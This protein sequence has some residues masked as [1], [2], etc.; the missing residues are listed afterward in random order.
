MQT[1]KKT[2]VLV[3]FF[4]E[5]LCVLATGEDRQFKVINASNELADNSAQCVVCTKTGRIIISTVGNLNFYDG[6]NFTHIDT[7]QDYQYQL[8]LYSGNYHLY[9]DR[10]HHL[11]LKNTH[12]VTCVDLLMEKFIANPDSVVR[13]MG[14][15]EPV[16][17]FFTD[18]I[19]D[20][21]VVTEKGLCDIANNR[22]FQILR[23][24]NLQDISVHGNLLLTFYDN[25]EE[26]GIDLNT[27]GIAHRSK[28][29]EWEDARRYASSTVCLNDGDV[30]YQIRNGNQCSVL[31]RFDL[32]TLQWRKIMELPY[33]LNDL[34]LRNG[35]LYIASAYGYWQYDTQ[36]EEKTHVE[37]LALLNGTK[38]L[39][40]CNTLVFDKQGGM[41]I[42]TEQRGLLYARPTPPAFKSYTWEHPLAGKYAAMFEGVTQ[43]ITEFNGKKANCMYVDSRN[44]SWFGTTTGLYLYRSPK[45]EPIVFSRQNG[46][47]NNV[48]HS[49]VEDHDHNVWVSTSNGIS[50]VMVRDGSPVFVNSFDQNDNV[51]DE[52]F[53]NCKALCLDDGTIVMQAL[54]H[55]VT[56]R[57]EEMRNLNEENDIRLFPKLVK[58][59]VNGS[60]VVPG[61]ER[62]GNM[63]I[64]RAVSRIKDIVL[65]ADQNTVSLTFSG[66]NYYRPLQTYY[67]W[68]VRE[69]SEEWQTCSYYSA[70]ENI[71]KEGMLHLPFVGLKPGTYTLH[72]EAS[73]FPD[74]WPD[75]PYEWIIHV[76]QPWWQATGVYIGIA[77]V[78]LVFLVL[79]LI[80]F[81]R[82]TRMRA[83]RNN[84]ELDV[85]RKIRSFVDRCNLL[86]KEPLMPTQEELYGDKNDTR[87]KLAPEFVELMMKL[88]PYVQEHDNLTMRS[89]S[90]EGGIDIVR[91]YDVVTANIYKNPRELIRQQRLQ[92]AARLL[93][94]TDKG[95]NEI[96]QECGFGSPNYFIGS[97]FHQ[98]KLTPG[99]Y[100]KEAPIQVAVGRR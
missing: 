32:R 64:D 69:L 53:S 75:K 72:V 98:Y 9:F 28:A 25:G 6:A 88:V 10:Y 58:I 19:G 71:D 80:V 62:D 89:L 2:G 91:L 14:C 22:T 49:I 46:L 39:T 97:F 42:G 61:E 77:A 37:R 56:F 65:K 100:R 90:E 95:V 81:G 67:R 51:P 40:D 66:L 83:Q 57:P 93:V 47:N 13:A 20:V 82:N 21:W 74:V 34:S 33:N 48:V 99:E 96:A 43:N 54:D 55:I 24:R 26:I 27:G 36:T 29:Y 23:D 12:S 7:R 68:R 44:W 79:N 1:I 41:W 59:L 8:P 52:S 86:G 35:V 45:E 73:M 4:L 78:I 16:L 94:T 50:V 5:T 18:S 92:A 15:S 87:N 76:N 85:I 60:T 17:D 3:L 63:I 38:L 30:Y 84:E 11:W 70:S 31:L